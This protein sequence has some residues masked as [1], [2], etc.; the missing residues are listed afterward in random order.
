MK[1]LPVQCREKASFV[2]CAKK[3]FKE[4]YHYD[5]PIL[6]STE[7]AI[8]DNF[9][10]KKYEGKKIL[11]VGGGPSTNDYEWDASNYDFVFSCNFFFKHPKLQNIELASLSPEVDINSEEFQNYYNNSS[12]LFV[13]ENV[14]ANQDY[15]QKMFQGGRTAISVVRFKDKSGSIGRLLIMLSSFKPAEVHIIGMDGMPKGLGTGDDCKHSFEQG[16]IMKSKSYSYDFYLSEST[17]LWNYL[18]NDIGKDIK[19]KNLGHGHPYN[20]LTQLNIL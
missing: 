3:Q 2:E 13:Y 19:F 10:Y 18:R 11:V 15:V 8:T 20:I 16:K 12:T 1:Y 5:G 7:L 9:N 17:K 6:Y 14:D 4:Y